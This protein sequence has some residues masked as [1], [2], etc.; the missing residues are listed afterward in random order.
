[1]AP[2]ALGKIQEKQ[3]QREVLR[4]WRELGQMR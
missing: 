2:L 1:M 4:R 3:G